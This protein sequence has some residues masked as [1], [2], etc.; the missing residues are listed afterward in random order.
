MLANFKPVAFD[1][2]G[3]RRS[4]WRLPRWLL[5]LVVGVAAGVAGVIA[6]QER[7]LPPRLSA[8]EASQLRERL[9][10]AEQERD[11]ARSDLAAT[12]QKLNAESAERKA[13]ADELAADRKQY[14]QR[15]EAG[16]ATAIRI[17]NPHMPCRGVVY[18]GSDRI[19][20]AVVFCDPGAASGVRLS[21]SMSFADGDVTQ[22][23]LLDAFMRVATNARYLRY[24]AP[25]AA[26][27]S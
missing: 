6:V 27:K 18:E 24:V 13:L 20:D 25:P 9:T 4:S 3:R 5:F 14:L 23:A 11:R 22:R 1:P 8:A 2:Y 19:D 12:A 21:W 10:R 15:D 16:K 26:K 7:L 17:H